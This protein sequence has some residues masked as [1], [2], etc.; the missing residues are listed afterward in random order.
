MD[1]ET[2]RAFLSCRSRV[3]VPEAML[4]VGLERSRASSVAMARR[5]R[6]LGWTEG[7][8][9]KIQ[10][11]CSPEESIDLQGAAGVRPPKVDLPGHDSDTASDYVPLPESIDPI[12]PVRDRQ[13]VAT[14]ACQI[15][16]LSFRSVCTIGFCWGVHVYPNDS[17][18]VQLQRG[19]R[20]LSDHPDLLRREQ[21]P[22]TPTTDAI[23][24]CYSKPLAARA[25]RVPCRGTKVNG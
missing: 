1:D 24:D 13:L 6:E 7:T 8:R 12:D 5:L 11:W 10:V 3:T 16:A 21:V 22:D 18:Q 17:R 25:L 20:Y 14:W 2:L 9:K 4:A 23:L 15:T 19:L